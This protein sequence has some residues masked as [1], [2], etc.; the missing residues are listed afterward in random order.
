MFK[1]QGYK[2]KAIPVQ[3]WTGPLGSIR[4]GATEFLENKHMKVARLS[5]LC[6]IH[7]YTRRY[8]WYSFLS[9]A[10]HKDI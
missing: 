6:T 8:L 1:T 7:L 10:K 4:L 9:K 3:A 2:S 5:A